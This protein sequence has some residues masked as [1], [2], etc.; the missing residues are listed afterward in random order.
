MGSCI[1]DGSFGRDGG[2][3]GGRVWGGFTEEDG[4]KNIKVFLWFSPGRGEVAV[5]VFFLMVGVCC[6]ENSK[7]SHVF[8]LRPRCCSLQFT[9]FLQTV[10]YLSLCDDVARQLQC[11]EVERTDPKH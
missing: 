9:S 4:K 10:V 7:S 5:V 8:C 6:G 1:R 3:V 2:V 11:S